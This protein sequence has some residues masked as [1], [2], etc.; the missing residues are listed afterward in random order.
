MSK[1]VINVDGEDRV[2]REDTAKAY[3]G[4]RWFLGT[5]LIFVVV[6]A[7][8]YFVFFVYSASDGRLNT[9]ETKTGEQIR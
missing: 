4:V 9:P 7:I 3:R 6:A 2:V 5:V 8:L 1:E